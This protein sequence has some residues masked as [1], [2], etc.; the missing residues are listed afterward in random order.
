MKMSF[1]KLG[2]V[3]AFILFTSSL[4]VAGAFNQKFLEKAKTAVNE[5]HF[6]WEVAPIELKTRQGNVLVD[7]DEQIRLHRRRSSIHLCSGGQGRYSG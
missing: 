5:G 2:F 6:K 1:K 4:A 3:F 7:S